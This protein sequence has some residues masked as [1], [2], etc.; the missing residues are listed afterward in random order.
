MVHRVLYN[1]VGVFLLASLWI[2]NGFRHW[3]RPSMSGW[4]SRVSAEA[5]EVRLRRARR[6]TRSY[7]RATA[8]EVQLRLPRFCWGS[9][10]W[11]LAASLSAMYGNFAVYPQFS[12]TVGTCTAPLRRSLSRQTAT[13]MTRQFCV[14]ILSKENDN[15]LDIWF[16]TTKWHTDQIL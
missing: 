9:R 1:V 11:R 7:T 16:D 6:R 15:V 13:R 10:R 4:G 14:C 8:P 12:N 2:F 3:V 5:P